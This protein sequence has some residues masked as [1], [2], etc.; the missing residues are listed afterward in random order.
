MSTN[1]MMMMMMD[2]ITE[3]KSK[4]LNIGSTGCGFLLVTDGTTT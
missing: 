1:G 4:Y 2:D 3:S